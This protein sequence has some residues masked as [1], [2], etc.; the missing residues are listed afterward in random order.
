MLETTYNDYESRREIEL[1]EGLIDYIK[2]WE[3]E[4]KNPDRITCKKRK[5]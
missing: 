5:A 4:S 1:V 3:K 2:Y